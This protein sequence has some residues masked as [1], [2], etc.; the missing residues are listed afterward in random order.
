M[1]QN[2]L[3]ELIKAFSI[4]IA[5][6]IPSLVSYWLGV[7]LINKKKLETN[8]KDA[9][10]DLEFLLT[11][12]SFHCREHLE[13]TGKS[14]R[15]IIRQSVSIETNLSWSGKFSLSRIKKKRSTLN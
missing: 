2:V 10:N 9:M 12:E 1:E 3:V 13:N 11:V 14:N 4:V 8:L 7:R 6:A 15:N 5:S